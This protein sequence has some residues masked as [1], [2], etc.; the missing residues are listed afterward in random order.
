MWVIFFFFSIK[1]EKQKCPHPWGIDIY[2]CSG[3]G[4]IF[5]IQV[6]PS[7]YPSTIYSFS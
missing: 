4:L 6:C 2:F 3:N 5:D 1:K 7:E